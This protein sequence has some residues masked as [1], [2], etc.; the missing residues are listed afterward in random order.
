M[1]LPPIPLENAAALRLRA[2]LQALLDQ[3]AMNLEAPAGAAPSADIRGE[4]PEYKCYDHIPKS[5]QN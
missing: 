5:H 1:H 4:L 3:Q 2:L